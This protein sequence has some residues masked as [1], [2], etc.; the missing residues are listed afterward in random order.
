MHPDIR[1]VLGHGIQHRR[2]SNRRRKE[3]A[4]RECQPDGHERHAEKHAHG[5]CSLGSMAAMAPRDLQEGQHGQHNCD[6]EDADEDKGA[7]AHEFD[8]PRLVLRI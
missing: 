6:C 4:Y 3:R 2:I 8:I 7:R 1:I 5:G